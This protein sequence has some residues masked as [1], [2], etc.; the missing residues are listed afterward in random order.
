NTKGNAVYVLDAADGKVLYTY[1]TSRAV[2]GDVSLVDIDSDGYP[3]YAY[4]AD[5]GGNLYRIAFIEGATG[6]ALGADKWTARKIAYTNGAGR[7]FLFGPSLLASKEKKVYVAI[8]SGD[9]ERPLQTDYP[10]DSVIN[11]FYVY[12][13]DLSPAADAP[14]VDMDSLA[15]YT[16]DTGATGLAS[17]SLKGWFMDLNQYGQGEQ[18]VTSALIAGGMVAF[19]TNRPIAP[20]AGTCATTLG[21]ARGYWVNL[22]NGSGAIGVPGN[23]GGSRSSVFV[24][25]GLPP[26]PVLASGVPIDG[27]P[28]TIVIGGAQRQSGESVS[29]SPQQLRPPISMKRKRVYYYHSGN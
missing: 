10:F 26:S 6:K 23:S 9:R 8:G 29:I 18:T 21:E 1:Q 14:A 27:K 25:G 22:L 24:G 20:A 15:D 17:S 12:R 2:A 4:A 3:D 5:T 11:R 7:K 13:D 19:S 16:T 28:T